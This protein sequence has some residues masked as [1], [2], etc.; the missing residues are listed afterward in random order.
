MKTVI[1][2]GGPLSPAFLEKALKERPCDYLIAAD[3]GLD[4]CLEAGVLP[5]LILG[6]FDSSRRAAGL[7]P[8]IEN[9]RY[10]CRKDYSDLEAA[11]HEAVDRG[12]EEITVLG[13]VG[14]R[15][16]H[17]L[18]AVMNLTIPL[19]AGIPARIIDENNEIRLF[20][21]EFCIT[22]SYAAGR[23]LSLLPMAGRVTG[24]TLRGV[25]YPVRGAEL[26]ADCASFGISNEITGAEACGEWARGTL[27]AV[28]SKDA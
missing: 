24:L 19:K 11:F 1:A 23:D 21:K 9:L 5:D 28:L 26:S 18:A 7:P 17:F 20:E 3:R 4:V 22:A 12:S 25:S 14:G 13:A 10:P 2:A 8:E 6:D 15:L 27:I 16:D